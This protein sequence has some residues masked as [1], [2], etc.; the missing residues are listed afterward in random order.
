M[1]ERHTCHHCGSPLVLHTEAE[2]PWFEHDQ[3]SANDYSLMHC[4][5]AITVTDCL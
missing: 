4:Q 5:Y 3:R 2:R 1:P